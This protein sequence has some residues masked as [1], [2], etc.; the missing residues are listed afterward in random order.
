[1]RHPVKTFLTLYLCALVVFLAC[2]A[3]WLG[4]V[5]RRFYMD[6]IGSLLLD[7]PN[8]PVAGAFYL[9]YLVGVVVFAMLPGL[10]TGSL[11]TALWRGALLGLVAY[12][13][14]DLTNLSTLKGF[15]ARIALVDMAWGTVLTGVVAAF[16]LWLARRWLVS[17]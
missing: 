15:T 10:E 12:G 6:E 13:T 2:D 3:V 14:Y 8:W 17:S 4:V 5:A 1:M 7:P 9:L 16:G 11:A